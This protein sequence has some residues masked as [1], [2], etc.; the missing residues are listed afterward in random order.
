MR[1]G[2]SAFAGDA[3]KSGIGQYLINIIKR[4][5]LI[6][7]KD[8][9]VVFCPRSAVEDLQ[10]THPRLEVVTT[11]DWMEKPVFSILWHLLALPV[12]L[13]RHRCECVFLPAGNRRLGW[14]YPVPS[15]G[16]VHDLSQL[17]VK[18]KYDRFRMY[19]VCNLLPRFMRRLTSVISVSNA[20]RE[21]LVSH[22]MVDPE[23]IRVIANG[24]DHLRFIDKDRVK[25]AALVKDSYGA[26]T[27]YLLYVA[28]LEHPGKNHVGL[29]K[30][31]A[32]LKAEGLPHQLVLAGS[33]W[34][35]A[36]FIEET[37]EKLGLTEDVK[38]TGFVSNEMLPELYAG[39]DLFVFP[40]LF[41]GFGI[42]LLESMMSGTPVCAS[43]ASSIPEVLGDAGLLFDPKDPRSIASSIRNVLDDPGVYAALR[44]A[45]KQRAAGFSWEASASQV[46]DTL[47]LAVKS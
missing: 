35:G 5:P 14:W 19:Y 1:I 45:G 11:P 22:A 26:S 43:D 46:L 21:D 29:L 20:T 16:T 32:I 34:N 3:G 12:M 42:P 4:L 24:F 37:V 38:F 8:S 18:G 23:K 40:S 10:L 2:I 6:S 36:E 44:Q 30:A 41:E 27:P 47:H 13:K 15:V 9:F 25:A 39:A 33:R 31:F 7:E 28:R 17:H